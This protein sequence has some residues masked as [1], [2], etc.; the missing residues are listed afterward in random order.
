MKITI[1]VLFFSI[2]FS[3]CSDNLSR[4]KA[5]EII[6]SSESFTNEH[7]GLFMQD[8]SFIEGQNLGLWDKRGNIEPEALNEVT[9]IDTRRNQLYLS[10]PFKIAVKTISGI[11][12]DGETDRTV[13]FDWIYTNLSLFG[14][15]FAF[16]GGFGTARFKL[17]DDGWRLNGRPKINVNNDIYPSSDEAKIHVDE[18]SSS[19]SKRKSDALAKYKSL[20]ESCKAD[21]KILSTFDDGVGLW[22]YNYDFKDRDGNFLARGHHIATKLI[23]NEGY[24][25]IYLANWDDPLRFWLGHHKQKNRGHKMFDRLGFKPNFGEFSKS[26]FKSVYAHQLTT[27]QYNLSADYATFL[28]ESEY[29]RFSQDL[30]LALKSWVKKCNSFDPWNH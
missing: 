13:E 3:G 4:E 29:E 7:N 22:L 27:D 8:L 2:F 10:K 23:L 19:I 17:Y 15:R 11:T 6:Q 9:S 5:K 25:L 28:S 21:G 1:L 12:E 14:Q 26:Q 18:I 30:E 20:I 16:N 24:V